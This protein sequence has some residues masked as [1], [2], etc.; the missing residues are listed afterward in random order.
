MASETGHFNGGIAS[1]SASYSRQVGGNN[2]I[3]RQMNGRAAL[4]TEVGCERPPL[5]EV[6]RCGRR[7]E[8]IGGPPASVNLRKSHKA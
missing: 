1:E 2:G 7:L 4:R 6:I 8:P 5:G 3:Q